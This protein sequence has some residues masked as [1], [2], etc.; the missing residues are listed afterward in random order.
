[1]DGQYDSKRHLEQSPYD[2]RDKLN[3]ST[4]SQSLEELQEGLKK[5]VERE[6]DECFEDFL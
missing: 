6:V 4:Y 1:L 5:L 2:K 3:S